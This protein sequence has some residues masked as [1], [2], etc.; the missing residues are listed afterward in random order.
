MGHRWKQGKRDCAF[1]ELPSGVNA[2]GLLLPEYAKICDAG[3]VHTR[4]NPRRTQSADSFVPYFI[5]RRE[6]NH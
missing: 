1:S 6:N 4:L 3:V 5:C 2:V